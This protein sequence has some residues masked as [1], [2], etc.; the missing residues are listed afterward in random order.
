V[1]KI[2]SAQEIYEAHL[3][4]DN[5]D[6]VQFGDI[7]QKVEESITDERPWRPSSEYDCIPSEEKKGYRKSICRD[8]D[9]FKSLVA[10]VR[11]VAAEETGLLLGG[12][13]KTDSTGSESSDSE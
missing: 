2:L 11:K 5:G 12:K 9:R 10:S 6:T 4:L 7:I 3:C 8:S 1:V 13:E